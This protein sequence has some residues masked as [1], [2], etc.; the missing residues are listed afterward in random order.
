M[1]LYGVFIETD[2]TEGNTM[3]P[4]TNH[5]L[6]IEGAIAL[7]NA[8]GHKV[9]KPRAP[10][11]TERPALNCLGLP[12]SPLYDP[13]WKRKQPLTSIARLFAPQNNFQWRATR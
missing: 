8:A 10:K 12:M 3:Q 7:L 1:L 13:K 4:Q 2:T 9:S 5:G 11:I 6:T